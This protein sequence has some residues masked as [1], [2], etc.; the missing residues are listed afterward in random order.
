MAQAVGPRLLLQKLEF[1]PRSVHVRFVVDRVA[2]GRVALNRFFFSYC[3]SI[4]CQ[5]HST[6]IK[7]SFH[8]KTTFARRTSGRSLGTFRQT[9]AHLDIGRTLENYSDVVFFQGNTGLA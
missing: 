5:Y 2:L 1:D 3:L 8:L 4:L 9:N 7:Y 6:T